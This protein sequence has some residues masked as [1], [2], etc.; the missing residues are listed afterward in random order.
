[1]TPEIPGNTGL[2]AGATASAG[3]A[4][5]GATGIGRAGLEVATQNLAQVQTMLGEMTRQMT[6]A[7][8]GIGQALANVGGEAVV[9]VPELLAHL[10]GGIL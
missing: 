8:E 9:H 3:A 1:M 7:M 4:V 5:E 6:G 2:A 10:P